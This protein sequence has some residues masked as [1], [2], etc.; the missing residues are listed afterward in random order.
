MLRFTGRARVF[1]SETQATRAILA[2]RIKPGDC[3]VIRYEGPAGGPGMREMLL[4]T[5][6]LAG[7]GL[8]K[9]VA[10]ITDGRFSGGT[11]GPCVGYISPEAF[12]AGPIAVLKENDLIVIDIPN[13]TVRACV[14]DNELRRRLRVWRPRPARVRSGYLV[15]YARSVSSAS[16]GAVLDPGAGA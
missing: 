15:R 4:P 2:G 3:L 9:S 7:Q 14:S 5:A 16:L 6:A 11:R 12:R 13:R 8:D 10:L 1:E